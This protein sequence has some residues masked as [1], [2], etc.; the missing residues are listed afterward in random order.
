MTDPHALA[1][2]ALADALE[3]RL[4][5]MEADEGL[6]V[7]DARRPLTEA[8]KAAGTRFGDIDYIVEESTV[9]AEPLIAALYAGA[10]AWL[11]VELFSVEENPE[12]DQTVEAAVIVALLTQLRS[13]P[14]AATAYAATTARAAD[15]L[16]EVL[17]NAHQAG[18]LTVLDEAINQGI[19]PATWVRP[20]PPAAMINLA[21]DLATHP[22]Q[23][24]I[25]R[26]LHEYQKPGSLL[27]PVVSLT[28]FKKF[29]ED[30]SQ[31]GTRD[32]V[33]QG[34]QTALSIGR[35]QTAALNTE[36][37]GGTVTAIASEILDK[38]TCSACA[39]ID[40]TI[41]DTLDDALTAYPAGQYARCAGGSRCRGILIFLHEQ[42]D[43]N[44]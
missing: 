6:N 21:A 29:I 31:A 41:F 1:A 42:P 28:E 22:W 19:N 24:V 20:K 32:L 26:A 25:E 37:Q 7:S 34:A 8:E 14:P 38:A 35:N 9:T 44:N 27:G 23:R 33:H 12:E 3:A 2:T 4:V 15:L 36:L 11:L 16:G 30:T 17:T 5:A 13:T 10:I 43:T 18:V 39:S 40:G